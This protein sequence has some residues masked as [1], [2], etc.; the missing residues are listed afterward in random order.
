MLHFNESPSP[1]K[2]IPGLVTASAAGLTIHAQDV[3]WFG[4]VYEIPETFVPIAY[5]DEPTRYRVVLTRDGLVLDDSGHVP[6]E[7]CY[8]AAL[9]LRAEGD[10]PESVD[11]EVIRRTCTTETPADARRHTL[12]A[13]VVTPAET[14]ERAARRAQG[15]RIAALRSSVVQKPIAEMTIAELRTVVALLAETAGLDL[16]AGSSAPKGMPRG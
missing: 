3:R 16:G 6:G 12:P 10:T 13:E 1:V 14:P 5:L 15:Q 9:T 11:V 4:D 2:S 7:I 8:L